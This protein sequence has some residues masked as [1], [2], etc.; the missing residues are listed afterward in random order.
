MGEKLHSPAIS[1]PM[2][3]ARRIA[4]DERGG[5]GRAGQHEQANKQY[6]SSHPLQMLA[7]KQVILT[8][9]PSLKDK[10]RSPREV[11]IPADVEED[12]HEVSCAAER[13]SEKALQQ[14]YSGLKS[15]EEPED[16]ESGPPK[17]VCR[18]VATC[19]LRA[20]A[21]CGSITQNLVEVAEVRSRLGICPSVSLSLV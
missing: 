19:A 3:P 16:Q 10:V 14:R 18:H 9:S 12:M 2:S 1:K 20:D 6:A 13:L 17:S 8:A 7:E 4:F 21:L 5:G 15:V 11:T